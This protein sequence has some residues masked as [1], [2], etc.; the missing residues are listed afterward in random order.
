MFLVAVYTEVIYGRFNISCPHRT[1]ECCHGGGKIQQAL[2]G[3]RIEM[4]NIIYTILMYE[5]I[6]C[7]SVYLRNVL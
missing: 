7:L 4:G 3:F 6:V 5:K 1:G 2:T